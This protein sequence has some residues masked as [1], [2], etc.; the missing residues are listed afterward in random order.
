M[1]QEDDG[2]TDAAD[3]GARLR[4]SL[5]VTRRGDRLELRG[6]VEGS[7]YPEFAREAFH[8]VVHGA[9]PAAVRLDGAEV[10]AAD[11]RF[12]LPNAGADLLVELG[13]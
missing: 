2:L 8:L 11:G 1:L 5:E 4:T 12:V 9:A 7:G 13:L 10:G 6:Q 3:G